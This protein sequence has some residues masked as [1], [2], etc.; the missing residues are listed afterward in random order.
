MWTPFSCELQTIFPLREKGPR[1]VNMGDVVKTL[2]GTNSLFFYRRNIFSMEGSLGF[3]V[4]KT[5]FFVFKRHF[6]ASKLLG[7]R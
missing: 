6:E 1:R 3:E 5:L 7:G 4:S 2:R